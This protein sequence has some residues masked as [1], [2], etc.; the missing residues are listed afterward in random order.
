MRFLVVAWLVA[1]FGFRLS[2]DTVPFYVAT[3]TDHPAGGGIYRGTLDPA[4][5]RL[6]PLVLAAPALNPNFLAF[7]PDGAC[8]YA[9]LGPESHPVVGAFAVKPSGALRLL[10]TRPA[11]GLGTCHVSVD[12]SGRTLFAANYTDGTVSSFK[13]EPDG[14]LG[15]RTARL[16][17]HGSGPNAERQKGPHLHSVYLSPDQAFVYACDL[18]SDRIWI[19]RFDPARGILSPNLPPSASS[20]SGSGPRHLD[21]SPDG[22]TVDV[23]NEMGNSVS[24]FAR[25]ASSGALALTQ[26]VSVRASGKPDPKSTSA[27]IARHPSGKWL[28][29][30]TRGCDTLSVFAI[31][32]A[33]RLALRQ[34]VPA[35]VKEPRSF[36]LDP[37]GHWLVVAGQ[38]DGRIAVWKIDPATGRLSATG[39]SVPVRGPMC[40]LFGKA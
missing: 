4:T 35:G 11:G 31:G 13:I 17:F 14:S 22:K 37:T 23:V 21:F 40:V 29:V 12:G 19:F 39:R 34:N 10:D 15:A 7:A 16:A 38:Q 5:G 33:G 20:P 24:V 25:D 18:G 36:A 8:L 6:G 32:D 3:S 28:Y 1:G 26:T 2:A 27:E 30:S 9:C